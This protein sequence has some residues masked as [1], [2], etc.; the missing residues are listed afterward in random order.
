MSKLLNIVFLSIVFM[1]SIF[2]LLGVGAE[3]MFDIEKR[4]LRD[5]PS[6]KEYSIND[7]PA[8][9]VEYI[10]DHFPLRRT[11]MKSAAISSYKLFGSIRSDA[12][13]LGENRF[14]FLTA[15]DAT[16][17]LSDYQGTNTFTQQQTEEIK[18]L[19]ERL[20]QSAKERGQKV[21]LMI[22]PNKE[23]VYSQYLPDY[24]VRINE[25]TRRQQVCELLSRTELTVID[26]TERLLSYSGD[27][28]Q[29]YH[30]ADTHWTG[31][32]AYIATQ[33]LLEQLGIEHI[34]YEDNSFES[35][36]YYESDIANLCHLYDEYTDTR[37]CNA[38]YDI[39]REKSKLSVTIVGDS[40]RWR[41]REY[42][43]ESF[44][45]VT[46]FDHTVTQEE[47]KNSKTDVLV[48]EVVERNLAGIGG[49]LEKAI[50]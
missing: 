23:E 5:V 10:S 39:C 27:D 21:V 28:T 24:F 50:Y 16:S 22:V 43:D 45:Q 42:M 29:L 13:A 18:Q 12:V 37:E 2:F 31:K 40:F 7:I 1:F 33:Q 11:I 3:D 44:G 38:V 34:R 4:E 41:M 49:I 30:L 8:A 17:P 14:L 35:G 47:L 32:G 46:E 25:A 19:A 26:P 6:L 9:Y 15:M 36:D 48:L 20:R